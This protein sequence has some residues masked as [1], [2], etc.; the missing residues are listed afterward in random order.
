[1]T[2]YNCADEY[3]RGRASGS[4]E[5]QAQAMAVDQDPEPPPSPTAS[6]TPTPP[7]PPTPTPAPQRVPTPP[8]PA[9]PTPTPPPV[10]LRDLIPPPQGLALGWRG[11]YS[12]QVLKLGFDVN[13]D[14]VINPY[15]NELDLLIS[16]GPQGGAGA[17]SAWTTGPLVFVDCPNNDYLGE[18]GLLFPEGVNMEHAF[19]G[20]SVP[21]PP[22]NI[23]GEIA[24]DIASGV[25]SCQQRYNSVPKTPT[26]KCTTQHV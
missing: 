16:V 19:G 26:E 14:L 12:F 1:M 17:G 9:T 20:G 2:E 8:P 3:C 4:Q 5:P 11:E 10:P 21:I 6:E 15:S 23:E 13:G 7:R 24:H 18:L 22:V 25:T